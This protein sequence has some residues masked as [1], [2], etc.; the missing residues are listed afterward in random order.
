[1]KHRVVARAG[2]NFPKLK[3]AGC[4]HHQDTKQWFPATSQCDVKKRFIFPIELRKRQSEIGERGVEVVVEDRTTRLR[5]TLTAHPLRK[6][7]IVLRRPQLKS[8]MQR[9]EMM[10]PIFPS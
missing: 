5:F 1:L 2:Q 7:R 3:I 9:Q 10:G 8:S 4:N 6:K